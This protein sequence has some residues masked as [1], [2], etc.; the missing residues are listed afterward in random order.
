M[1]SNFDA[2]KYLIENSKSF[3][4]YFVL[5]RTNAFAFF[6]IAILIIIAAVIYAVIAKNV[7]LS[8]VTLRIKPQQNVLQNN[9]VAFELSEAKDRRLANEIETINNYDT[10]ERFAEAL[11]DSFNNSSNKELFKL[12]RKEGNGE[13]GPKS[14]SGIISL[15]SKILTTEQV[16]GLDIV[17]LTAESPSPYEAALIANTCAAV[18]QELNLEENRAELTSL[19][20]FLEKQSVEKLAELQQLE[21]T[22]KHF[23]QKGR[24]VSLDA[25][26]N[27][28]INQLSQLD[29][30]RDAVKIDL[31]SSGEILNQYKEKIHNQNPQLAGYLESKTSQA[32]IEILQ[33]EIAELQMNR[34]LALANKNPNIDASSKVSDYDRRISELK[35]KLNGM[36]SNIKADAFSSSPEQIR[37]LSQ[38]LIETDINNRSLAI[39]FNE[40]QSVI[41]KYERE[42]NRLPKASIELAQYQRKRD[43][44]Q[45]LY[46]L[47]EQKYQQAIINELSKP[48]NVAIIGRGRIPDINDPDKPNRIFIV[49]TGIVV[50]LG[51]A[52]GYVFM[53][54]RFDDTIKTPEDVQNKNIPLLT[55]IPKFRNSDKT[56]PRH[57]ELIFIKEPDSPASESFRALRAR[58]EFSKV[59]FQD[60]KTILVTSPAAGEGKSVVSTNLALSYAKSNKKTLLID[61]DLRKPRINNIMK[62]DKTPGLVDYLFNKARLDDII[63][64]AGVSNF[65]YITAG[66]TPSNPA[67]VVDSHAM[68]KFLDTMKDLFGIIIIDS[69]PIVSVIDS[70]VLARVADGTLLVLS[71]KKTENKLMNEAIEIVRNPQV[72]FLGTVLNNFNYKKG[73]GYYNKY[74]YNYSSPS[75]GKSTKYKH[76]V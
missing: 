26:S 16:K 51:L 7:Y 2:N 34:D 68:K 48:G 66:T 31:M 69:A 22:L 56:D 37:D 64:S 67:E 24:I 59:D 33:K 74:F 1:E 17:H 5:V 70:E 41:D 19:R 58:I 42:L 11:I 32:Y 43:S 45:Q 4:D 52:F 9:E 76:N 23:Q 61:C 36:I 47:V 35:T 49:L 6:S 73:Y 25:Q 46:L 44:Y 65:N 10:K 54:D 63:R 72:H 18:F 71:S 50:G 55:W 29:V 8:T 30:Q 38:K 75:N 62:V 15:L 20:N 40:L 57:E 39:R 28:L 53:K 12:L 27:A 21:D 60:F 14:K 13:E 3:K